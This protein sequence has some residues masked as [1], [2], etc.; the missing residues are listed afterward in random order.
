MAAGYDGSIKISTKIDQSGFNSGRRQIEN[1]LNSITA[2]L[3]KVAAAMG[4]AFGV[5]AII[6][7][8]KQSVKAV[9]D[10][11]NAMIGLQSILEGQGRSFK[12]A[13]KFI[14][15][16]VS[17]GLIPA[18][19]AI[20]AYKNLASR[21]YNDEQIKQTLIALKDAAAFGR[22][23]SLTMGEAVKAASEGLK[24]E[25]SIL[26]DNSGITKNVAQMW[27]DYA[28]SIGVGVQSL[29]KQQ[30]I[31]A[32]VLGIMEETRFQTGDAAKVAQEYSGQVMKLGFNF[33]NLKIAIGNAILPI[34]WKV[35]PG[36]NAMIVGLTK[37]ANVFAQVSSLL[38]GKQA[39]AQDQV[40]KTAT[41][42]AKAENNLAKATEKA[43][44]AAKGALANFDEL[45]VL[46]ENTAASAG[47]LADAIDGAGGIEIPEVT[48]GGE[49][50]GDVEISPKIR[51]FIGDLKDQFAVLAPYVDRVSDAWGRFKKT[52]EDFISAPGVQAV[53]G[54]M[55]EFILVVA[56]NLLA[57]ALLLIA[58]VLDIL[59]GALDYLAGYLTFVVGIL[60]GDWNMAM[61]G[62]RQI[63]EGVKRVLQG[64][65][66]VIEAVLIA[67]LG[68]EAVEA[69][70][71][72]VGEWGKRIAAWWTED[73]A[74]WFTKGRWVQLWA[75][76]Q[77]GWADGW[78]GIG[79]WWNETIGGWWANSVSPWFTK[80]KWVELLASIKASFVETWQET[81]NW[82]LGALSDWWRNRV[83]PWFTKAK[84]LSVMS[85]VKEGFAETFHNAVEAAR[86]LFNKFI[87]WLNTKMKF[88]W[89]AKKIAGETIV[90]AGSIQ[91]FTIPPIPPLATGAVIPPNAQFAAILGD[92]T[93]G[94]N[95]ETPLETMIAAFNTALDARDSGGEITINNVLTLDGRVVYKNQK[96]YERMIGKNLIKGGTY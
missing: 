14:N 42:G 43:G 78:T 27:S 11:K 95:I 69:L 60:T 41:A 93:R 22:Q 29:T 4:L 81:D 32:E 2:S 64:L 92:Q 55:K 7:F 86:N 71:K 65:G 62:A 49:L 24:N 26:V 58:G 35:L 1:G 82:W 94:V 36:I 6:D 76:V 37:L 34:A 90:P 83:A 16:Y 19:D 47:G 68:R 20:T 84:W 67:A 39:K 66:E 5:K 88:S 61:D 77:Q 30:K 13:Q 96:K 48:G 38:F 21:G 40:T 44:K 10:L 53:L 50:F 9:T 56:D 75:D 3:K 12:D 63:V 52:L 89:D 57:T 45:N 18:T 51:Q 70:K 28:K 59:S 54:F 17:D 23:A 87:D 33:N 8:G 74:P 72:F 15:N 85:G 91:L 31:Q 46:T 79:T 73:V 80:A 25:N